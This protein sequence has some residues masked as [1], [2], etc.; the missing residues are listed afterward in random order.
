MSGNNNNGGPAFPGQHVNYI[1]TLG[2]VVHD[3]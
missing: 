1:E 2:N 3:Q